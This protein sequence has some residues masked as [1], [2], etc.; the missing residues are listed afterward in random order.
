MSL[1]P[2]KL[3]QRGLRPYGYL[4]GGKPLAPKRKEKYIF[5]S[6]LCYVAIDQNPRSEV[7]FDYCLCDNASLAAVG[8]ENEGK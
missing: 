6:V 8:L 5:S 2:A 7:K 4:I 1:R 3:P